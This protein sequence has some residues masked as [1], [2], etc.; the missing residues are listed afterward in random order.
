MYKNPKDWMMTFQ[1]YCILTMLGSHTQTTSK[2]TKII[3]RSLFSSRFCFVENMVNSGIL[4]RGMYNVLNEWYEH[5]EK[6]IHLQTDLIVYLRTSPEVVYQ[7]MKNRGRSEE[8]H[9]SLNYLTQLHSLHEDWLTH[10]KKHQP[11]PVSVINQNIKKV[12]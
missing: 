6:T 2:P 8:D 7:R 11:A 9:V 4:H 1:S 3:E 5:I 12:F 10:K